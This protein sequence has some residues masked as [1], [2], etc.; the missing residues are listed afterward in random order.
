MSDPQSQG[1]PQAAP[2]ESQSIRLRQRLGQK[3]FWLLL[4]VSAGLILGV[5]RWQPFPIIWDGGMVLHHITLFCLLYLA[6]RWRLEAHLAFS[7]ALGI[8]VL[9]LVFTGAP[10]GQYSLALVGEF[11]LVTSFGLL[12]IALFDY[13]WRRLITPLFP[14]WFWLLIGLFSLVAVG[15][16]W[17]SI[18]L[19]PY[20]HGENASW[21][22]PLAAGLCVLLCLQGRY[23]ALPVVVGL[24]LGY[25]WRL[26]SGH[27]AFAYTGDLFWLLALPVVLVQRWRAH[28]HRGTTKTD[29]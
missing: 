12:L 3:H 20:F 26:L 5:Q 17:I 10:L 16:Q 18:D 14:L 15:G 2:P 25:D 19:F 13:R 1:A 9:P 4:L 29:R 22:A 6:A 27:N 23:W 21:L 28:R 8:S 11:G 7:L 24:S